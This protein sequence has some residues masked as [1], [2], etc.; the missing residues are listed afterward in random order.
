[1]GSGSHGVLVALEGVLFPAPDATDFVRIAVV[2]VVIAFGRLVVGVEARHGYQVE[3][4][5]AGAANGRHV[6]VVLKFPA[7]QLHLMIVIRGQVI[8]RPAA[9]VG[10][11]SMTKSHS[12]ILHVDRLS[13]RFVRDHG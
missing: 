2:V 1:V 13:K 10:T 11:R 6:D 4:C 3:S 9:E 7:K 12:T 8:D 5:V